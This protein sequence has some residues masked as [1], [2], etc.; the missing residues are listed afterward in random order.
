M[1]PIP[2]RV[3]IP[4]YQ[5]WYTKHVGGTQAFAADTVVWIVTENPRASVE[6]D[7]R[8]VAVQAPYAGIV[9]SAMP[10]RFLMPMSDQPEID[11][12]ADTAQFNAG[13]TIRIDPVK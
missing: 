10:A 1:N 2:Y 4:A 12:D 11:P 3:D 7:E 8:M 9:V 13:D 6:S 5:V